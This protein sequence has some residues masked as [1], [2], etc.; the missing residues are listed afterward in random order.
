MCNNLVECGGICVEA[1]G[2]VCLTVLSLLINSSS[3]QQ[4]LLTVFYLHKQSTKSILKRKKTNSKTNF[5]RPSVQQDVSLLDI[6]IVNNLNNLVFSILINSHI[7]KSFFL[8][9]SASPAWGVAEIKG[10]VYGG[11]CLSFPKNISTGNCIFCRAF[12]LGFWKSSA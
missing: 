8:I 12:V 7:Q 1:V 2:V 11:C 5:W 3:E 6:D 10:G 4:L 9:G